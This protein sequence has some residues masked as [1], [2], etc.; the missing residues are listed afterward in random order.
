MFAASAS[1]K[2]VLFSELVMQIFSHPHPSL[3]FVEKRGFFCCG[4]AFPLP[5]AQAGCVLCTKAAVVSKGFMYSTVLAIRGLPLALVFFPE[6]L[7]FERHYTSS[8]APW[9]SG[10]G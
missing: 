7:F 1:F 6:A 2:A 9:I 10:G 8:Y 4:L 5:R 3:W